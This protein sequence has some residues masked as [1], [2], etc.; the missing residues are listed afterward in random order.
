MI[1]DLEEKND[2][3]IEEK[4]LYYNAMEEK[5][6]L[7]KLDD[8]WKGSYYIYEVLLKELYKIKDWMEEY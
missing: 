5:Q 4:L 6:W 7:G 3:Y 8:K 2:F 1:R